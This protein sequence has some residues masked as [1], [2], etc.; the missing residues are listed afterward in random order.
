MNRPRPR[1]STR[2]DLPRAAAASVPGERPFRASPGNAVS[3]VKAPVR[4]GDVIAEGPVEPGA[5]KMLFRIAIPIGKAQ[6]TA[7]FRSE[8]ATPWVIISL[9]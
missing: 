7:P 3:A 8:T 5:K 6:M 4:I 2:P 9:T 1:S